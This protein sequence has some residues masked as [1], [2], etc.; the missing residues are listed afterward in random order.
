M[1]SASQFEQE[2]IIDQLEDVMNEHDIPLPQPTT[3]FIISHIGIPRLKTL[4][5]LIGEAKGRVLI[6]IRLAL[7]AASTSIMVASFQNSSTGITL[8]GNPW[9][10]LL[11]A[12]VSLQGGLV[13]ILTGYILVPISLFIGTLIIMTIDLPMYW[14]LRDR[15]R[16]LGI[17][18]MLSLS[19]WL[20]LSI[21]LGIILESTI[22]WGLDLFP[23]GASQIYIL[24]LG[25][26]FVIAMIHGLCFIGLGR[27]CVRRFHPS[28]IR[29]EGQIVAVRAHLVGHN[30]LRWP[31]ADLSRMPN[32]RLEIQVFNR[33][34]SVM[35]AK[36]IILL[37][38][39]AFMDYGYSTYGS[40]PTTDL[41]LIITLS[42]LLAII[43]SLT[44]FLVIKDLKR[45]LRTYWS[46]TLAIILVLFCGGIILS[47]AGGLVFAIVLKL[48]GTIML[49]LVS[50]KTRSIVIERPEVLDSIYYAHLLK[51]MSSEDARRFSREILDKLQVVIPKTP[52]Q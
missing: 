20:L 32:S 42:F 7:L 48:V 28:F 2:T 29:L 12:F 3:G 38:T 44:V 13:F 4:L 39:S 46:A 31:F 45:G 41:N 35:W 27:E 9:N 5:S 14:L 40:L 37:I 52:N 15:P 51:Q 21:G 47:I 8:S 33:E 36:T 43:L 50:M 23:E 11:S 24:I 10:S 18:L 16:S 49:G 17:W 26:S 6:A 34:T 22:V 25:A 30:I 19:I 1:D